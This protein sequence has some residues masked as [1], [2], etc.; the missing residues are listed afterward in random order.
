MK[1]QQF[2]SFDR[3]R[4]T[5]SQKW[6]STTTECHQAALVAIANALEGGEVFVV[7]CGDGDTML[8]AI[9]FRSGRPNSWDGGLLRDP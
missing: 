1:R 7:V 8:G 2:T 9:G 3:R 5:V 4:E 6:N